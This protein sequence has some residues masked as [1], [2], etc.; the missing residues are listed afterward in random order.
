[1]NIDFPE[2][3]SVHTY[4]DWSSS[5]LLIIWS[6]KENQCRQSERKLHIFKRNILPHQNNNKC[7]CSSHITVNTWELD[8]GEAQPLF[9]KLP[10]PW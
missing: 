6:P 5:M 3:R 10:S 8:Q 4:I 1:M 9:T 7:T 2:S